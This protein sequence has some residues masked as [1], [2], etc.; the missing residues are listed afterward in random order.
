[1]LYTPKLCDIMFKILRKYF[2]SVERFDYE[3]ILAITK[4]EDL[5]DWLKSTSTI[6]GFSEENLAN[7]Y[8]YFEDIRIKD[9]A[10]NIPRE[11][12]VFISTK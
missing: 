10:I 1:M 5:M 3:N 2:T 4:T 8:Q 6:S 7:L 12:G 11:T 9:G